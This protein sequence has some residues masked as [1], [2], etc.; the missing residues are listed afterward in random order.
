MN[1]PVNNT[2][3]VSSAPNQGQQIPGM[4]C[5]QC[6]EFIPTTIQHIITSS[7]LVCPHCHLR[8]NIDRTKSGKAID[9]LRKVQKPKRILNVKRIPTDESVKE[10]HN[11]LS[12]IH[13]AALQ[14]TQAK[15]VRRTV[16]M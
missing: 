15:I 13:K 11:P 2:V 16:C 10:T 4:K 9:A 14:K 12:N 1:N 7:A 3:S 5:P 8:L 6:G